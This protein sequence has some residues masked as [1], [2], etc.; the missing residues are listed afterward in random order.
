[1][2]TPWL[3]QRCNQIRRRQRLVD[4]VGAGRCLQTPWCAIKRPCAETANALQRGC[5]KQACNVF[6][7]QAPVSRGTCGATDFAG[8][9]LRGISVLGSLA[10]SCTGTRPCA[11]AWA[12]NAMQPGPNEAGMQLRLRRSQP[13][14]SRLPRRGMQGESILGRTACAPSEHL[15]LIHASSKRH[16]ALLEQCKVGMGATAV[17]PKHLRPV[18]EK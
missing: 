15:R 9:P 8:E 3:H 12:A 6:T 13:H 16:A 17:R 2:L 11:C 5:R 10:C 4:K 1:M 18:P 7:W 14:P